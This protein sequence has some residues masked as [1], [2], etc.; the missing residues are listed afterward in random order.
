MTELDLQVPT[1]EQAEQ[2]KAVLRTLDELVRSNTP[3]H[4]HTP[5][6]PPESAVTL[7]QDV[8]TMLL[9]IL[10]HLANGDAV[11]VLPVQA[12]VTA[13]QAA[14]ILGVSR[15]FLIRL[16]DEGKIACRRVG[17]HRRIPLQDLMDFKRQ[18][19]AERRAIAAELTAEAQEQGF[20]K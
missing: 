19:K 2:A 12:E 14:E 13:Q 1:P 17:T 20:Y 8:L 15:P 9:R 6:S 5:D 3:I 16:V 11:T 4:L 7:P 10:G 18:N